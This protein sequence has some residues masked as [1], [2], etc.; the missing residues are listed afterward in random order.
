MDPRYR[1]SQQW[2]RDMQALHNHYQGRGNASCCIATA[3]KLKETLHYKSERSP[4]QH[5]WTA[6]KRC[7]ASFK[8]KVRSCQ[9]MLNV[10]LLIY[11]NGL[12]E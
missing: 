6:C 3:E 11:L 4:S 7:L 2:I 9:R 12:D 10:I 5:S 8:K 1:T